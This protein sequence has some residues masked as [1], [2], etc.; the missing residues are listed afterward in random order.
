M[1]TPFHDQET[2]SAKHPTCEEIGGVYVGAIPHFLPTFFAR[3]NI[4]CPTLWRP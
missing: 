1:K 3:P 4:S 2:E